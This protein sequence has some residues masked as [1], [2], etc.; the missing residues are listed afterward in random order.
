MTHANS[1]QEEGPGVEPGPVT[2][3][4]RE[5]TIVTNVPDTDDNGEV[6]ID[7]RFAGGHLSIT[8]TTLPHDPTMPAVRLAGPGFAVDL[9]PHEA[10][11]LAMALLRAV[12][13][14]VAQSAR[15]L[16]RPVDV[17]AQLRAMEG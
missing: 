7:A 13:N 16:R 3:S 11:S 4:M 6:L 14:S 12:P 9:F 1:R 5:E 2:R 8:P 10:S 15:R 17:D